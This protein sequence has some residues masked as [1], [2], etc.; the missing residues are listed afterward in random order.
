M[1]KPKLQMF[2][3]VKGFFIALWIWNFGLSWHWD[4]FSPCRALA[5][6]SHLGGRAVA[7]PEDDRIAPSWSISTSEQH[8]RLRAVPGDGTRLQTRAQCAGLEQLAT[9]VLWLGKYFSTAVSSKVWR[10]LV[11]TA[12]V[13]IDFC[14]SLLR[15]QIYTWNSKEKG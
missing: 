2:C 13:E 1:L 8:K 5:V 14:L 9:A 7:P 10:V 4:E 15:V 11:W 6:L 3:A 12:P